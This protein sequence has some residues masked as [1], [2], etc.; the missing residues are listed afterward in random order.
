MTK[1]RGFFLACGMF[2]L[3]SACQDKPEV[4]P[5]APS[6]PTFETNVERTTD[7]PLDPVVKRNIDAVAQIFADYIKLMK[8]KRDNPDSNIELPDLELYVN[9]A[10]LSRG[11]AFPDVTA[12]QSPQQ[13][14]SGKAGRTSMVALPVG[15]GD[16]PSWA[17]AGYTEEATY[18]NLSPAMRTV[19]D[20]YDRNFNSLHS[21]LPNYTGD[22]GVAAI[23][24]VCRLAYNQAASSLAGRERTEAMAAFYGAEELADDAYFYCLTSGHFDTTAPTGRFFKSRFWTGVSRVLAAV[25]TTA[26]VIAVPVAAVALAK[27]WVASGTLIGVGK[28]VGTAVAKALISGTTLG[29]FTAS[30]AV[31]TGFSAGLK[32]AVE[33]RDQD[34]KGL[35]EFKFGIKLKPK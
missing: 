11:L 33:N 35:V 18:E 13:E 2:L 4:A 30:A 3:V 7:H 10:L 12:Q 31:V 14:E 17:A 5:A 19:V 15:D 24:N 34:W 28:A 9:A 21:S 25:V 29:S 20:A 1:L 8:A 26:V 16:D 27:F 23:R 6:E 22:G 32:N